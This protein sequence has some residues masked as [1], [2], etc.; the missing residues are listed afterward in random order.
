MMKI[1]FS[2]IFWRFFSDNHFIFVGFEKVV[3]FGLHR[4]KGHMLYLL[5]CN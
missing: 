3:K 2:F 5:K 4:N 1:Y